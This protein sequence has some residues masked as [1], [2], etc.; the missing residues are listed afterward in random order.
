MLLLD[1]F[2]LQHN[3]QT[4]EGRHRP[5]K[6]SVQALLYRTPLATHS[7]LVP[8]T[9]LITLATLLFHLGCLLFH[10]N[11]RLWSYGLANRRH[12]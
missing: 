3:L 12:L 11:F 5:V 1:L 6:P 2:L 4:M 8:L 10:S 7:L 9:P